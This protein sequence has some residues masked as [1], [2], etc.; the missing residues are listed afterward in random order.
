MAFS[1]VDT[2]RWCRLARD[3]FTG[4]A[5]DRANSLEVEMTAKVRFRLVSARPSRRFEK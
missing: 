5:D 1:V 4:A 2:R 3:R